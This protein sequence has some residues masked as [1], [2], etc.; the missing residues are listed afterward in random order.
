MI[1]IKVYKNGWEVIGHSEPAICYQI[2]LWHWITS[3]IILGWR[4]GVDVKEYTSHRDN[5]ENPNEG[6]SCLTFVHHDPD[7][8]WLF[9]DMVVSIEKWI[10]DQ[11]KDGVGL[12]RIDGLLQK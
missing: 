5:K 4:H 12:E 6:Y 11:I 3:N 10:D 8:D 7:L 1:Q 9:E 2:S